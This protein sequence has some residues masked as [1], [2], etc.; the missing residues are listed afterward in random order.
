MISKRKIKTRKN[1][2]LDL[3]KFWV[4]FDELREEVCCTI[5]QTSE[6]KVE[7]SVRIK[8]FGENFGYHFRSLLQD[9]DWNDSQSFK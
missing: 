5:G 9:I 8:Y 4:T 1:E 6:R 3:R 7:V 2:L